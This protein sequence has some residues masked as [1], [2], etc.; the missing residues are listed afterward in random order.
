M[1][2][3]ELIEKIMGADS[4]TLAAIEKAARGTGANRVRTGTIR[5]AADILECHPQTI[6]RYVRMG[7]LT[8]K[9]ITKR[10]VR[11]DLD[12]CERLAQQGADMAGAR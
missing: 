5:Q 12:E 11:Y 3:A 6:Q 10:R 1:S 2:K 4:D 9:R 7:L 8:Q